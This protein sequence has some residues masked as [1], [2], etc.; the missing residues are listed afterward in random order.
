MSFLGGVAFGAGAALGFAAML[1]L[2]CLGLWAGYR[3]LG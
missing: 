2:L 3:A 1:A